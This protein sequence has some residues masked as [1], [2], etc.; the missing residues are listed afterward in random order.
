MR[1]ALRDASASL[2]NALKSSKISELLKKSPNAN[3]NWEIYFDRV[4]GKSGPDLGLAIPKRLVKRAVDRNKIKR[5]ARELF[6]VGLFGA[7][8]CVIKL[9]QAVGK[10][11]RAKLR[12]SE[13]ISLRTKLKELAKCPS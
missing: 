9:R 5:M 11:T 6:G 2:F 10:K 1:V 12:E 3:S 4:S 8:D 7:A 13:R